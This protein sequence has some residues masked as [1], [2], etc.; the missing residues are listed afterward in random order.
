[1]ENILAGAICGTIYC[2]FAG[3]PLTM[4]CPTGP[5]LIFEQVI[6]RMCMYVLLA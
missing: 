3:Q 6:F 1:M 5:V 4:I 2:L